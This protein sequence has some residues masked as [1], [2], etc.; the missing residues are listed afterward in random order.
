MTA[1]AGSKSVKNKN[2]MELGGK[3]LYLYNLMAAIDS[4]LINS[5]Y[6]TTDI[7]EI[8]ENKNKLEYSPISRPNSLAG[9]NASHYETIKHALLHAESIEGMQ[10]DNIL[11]ML[12]NSFGADGGLLDDAIGFLNSN[13]G[14]DSIMT[15]SNFNM[16]NPFRSY[17]IDDGKLRTTI[18]QDLIVENA[19]HQNVNDKKSAGDVFFFNGC[20]WLIRREVFM[21]CDGLLPF[22]WMGKNI[23]PW[24]QDV[25]MEIDAPW[26]IN[27]VREII[28]NA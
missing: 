11:V 14:Y 5:V 10:C 6:V 7:E 1:R 2:T 9:D 23:Y 15:V 19:K 8:I 16:F 28:E 22:P 21:E 25:Y 18:D 27:C 20:F 13:S 17:S 12:G 3:P 24:T 26:Q 4:K